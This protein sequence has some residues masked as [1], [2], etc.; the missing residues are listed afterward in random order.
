VKI[1]SLPEQKLLLRY[2]L[3]SDKS[4]S[5]MILV[6]VEKEL[7]FQ[8]QILEF[9]FWNLE[10][11]FGVWRPPPPLANSGRQSGEQLLMTSMPNI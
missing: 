8:S 10:F 7:S 3:Y 2:L 6:I 4:F 11:R 1:V 9:V 5:L